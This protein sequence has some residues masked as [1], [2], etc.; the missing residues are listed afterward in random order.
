MVV[1]KRTKGTKAAPE[2]VLEKGDTKK[3]IAHGGDNDHDT[4]RPRTEEQT[5]LARWRVRDDESRHTWH[6]LEDDDELK[7]WPQ[8]YAEKYFLNLP[9]VRRTIASFLSPSSCKN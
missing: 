6:Y 8:S 4:K 3:R 5:D 9:L 1:K 7:E 2:P